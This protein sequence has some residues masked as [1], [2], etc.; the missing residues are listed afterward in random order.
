MAVVGDGQ[1][2]DRSAPQGDVKD[3]NPV[4]Q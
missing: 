1:T 3:W 4:E 2:S